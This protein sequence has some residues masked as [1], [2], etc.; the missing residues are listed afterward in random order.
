[1]T[2]A[3]RS[4]Y[5]FGFYLLLTGVTLTV[6]PNMML[7]M[8]QIPETTEVWIRLLGTVVF[9]IGIYY[10]VMAPT[11]N[12]LFTRLTVY[13]RWSVFMWF[14]IFVV[15]GYA[16]LQLLLFGV[17]DL[18]GALWTYVVMKKG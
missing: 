3:S 10:V 17:I 13:V 18:A 1:M 15:I 8:V 2:A 7:A 11:N 12:V 14:V 6:F 9:A 16:P 5:Y 4:V